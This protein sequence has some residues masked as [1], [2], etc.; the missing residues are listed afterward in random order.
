MLKNIKE[1]NKRSKWKDRIP[2]AYWRGNP[3]V[4]HV[5]KDLTKCNVTDKQN[6][7]TLLYTQV[8]FLDFLDHNFPLIFDI[9]FEISTNLNLY[10][11]LN[12]KEFD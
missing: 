3:L 7:D 4:S 6:W 11:E 2:F 1:G 10:Y 5:R 12:F 8:Y 9:Y